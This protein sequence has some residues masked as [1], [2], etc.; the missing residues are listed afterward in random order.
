MKL[1]KLVGERFK[2]RPADCVID[3]HAIMVKGGYIKYMA[4][5]IY[6]SYLPLRRIVRKIEQI[7]REEMDKIDGQEVQFPV[8]MPASLWDESGRYDSIGDELLRFTDRNNAKMVL[9]MTHEEA[10]VHLV[11]EYAQSYT[12]YPFMI[13]QIQT[14]FR[15]EARPRAGLIRVREFTMKDAYSFHT[16]QEDLEQY[17]EKCHAAYER[18]FERVGVPEVVSVKSDSGMMG[19]N[20]SH[21]F[22]LLTPVGEDS[23]VLCDSCDYRANMEAAE[24]ISDIARDAESAALEKVYTPN[25]HT[26]EDVCN[27]FGDETKNSC[28]AVVYQQNVDEKY[29]VLFIRGDLE[30][31]ETKLVNFLGEQVHAAVITE[32]CGLNAGYIGPVNL[33]VNGDAVVLYDKSL[34]GR[35]NLS[36]GANEAEHHYKGLDMERDVP[37]A[38]YHDFAKIQEGGICPKCG[39]KTVKISRGIEVGNIFQLGTKYTKSMNM[40]YVDANGESKTP[41]MGCYGIGVGRLAASVCEAHHDEYGPIWPKAI[42][43]W[44]VHLCAVRVDDEEVRAYAD[45]LYEDLQ[46]AGIEVIYDDRSVRAGVMFAD[47]DLLGIPLRIIVSPKNMKQG[48]VEVA[49]RD[50]TLKTQIPL[51]NVMEEIKQYL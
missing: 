32:E 36:C 49:S 10:A 2:E 4:N 27:F 50:K 14:K 9:G 22:M 38:E 24:N 12:K 18:I 41:I 26:I 37:N 5:G 31:N 29:V 17:Y 6:S 15:D 33:K 8:V 48:V 30:V 42:A 43:P 46:N 39:K 51:E 23:I 20:I 45:K 44:Q 40:T 34:E 28:K 7:L 3:S 21:E 47:A 25:V 11:R 19:G 13:Y 1:E 35:N 16:S